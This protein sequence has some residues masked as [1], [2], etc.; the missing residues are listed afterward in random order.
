[1]CGKQ[2]G[3]LLEVMWMLWMFCADWRTKHRSV[4]W[5]I[6]LL[7][8]G[9]QL[10]LGGR[11]FD[12]LG[13]GGVWRLLFHFDRLCGSAIP[14]RR[15][16]VHGVVMRRR[17]RQVAAF[18]EFKWLRKK[19]SKCWNVRW[20]MFGCCLLCGFFILSGTCSVRQSVAGAASGKGCRCASAQVVGRRGMGS[21][22]ECL[23]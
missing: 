23:M 11:G 21:C 14:V 17:G 2:G 8:H 13:F 19:M 3:L 10:D 20:K 9:F 1:M 12:R 22:P 5:R 15:V 4:L 16:V 7:F 6:F 18:R